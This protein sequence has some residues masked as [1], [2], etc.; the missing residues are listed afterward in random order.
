MDSGE[1]L[2]S[3]SAW[4]KFSSSVSQWS[5]K[6]ASKQRLGSVKGAVAELLTE[7]AYSEFDE[8]W[9]KPH[10]R[11]PPRPASVT[12]EGYPG[13]EAN[14]E[15]EKG[16]RDS[17]GGISNKLRGRNPQQE[18]AGRESVEQEEAAVPPSPRTPR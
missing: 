9:S 11:R 15:S 17:G 5:S 18:E 4:K 3:S 16:V 10:P 8:D 2:N 12:G 14:R 7:L 1:S 6:H 13:G